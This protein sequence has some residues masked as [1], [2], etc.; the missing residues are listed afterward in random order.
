MS[1]KN[2]FTIEARPVKGPLIHEWVIYAY[3]LLTLC[4]VLVRLAV[5]K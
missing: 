4:I 1:V 3:A 5:H 2:I